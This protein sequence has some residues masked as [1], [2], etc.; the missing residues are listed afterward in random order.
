MSGGSVPVRYARAL[1][2]LAEEKQNLPTLQR[3]W[4]DLAETFRES[5]TLGPTLANPHL[6]L[7]QRERALSDLLDRL[8]A[9]PATRGAVRLLLQKGR[10]L[11]L[12]DVA[13]AFERM[14][15]ERTG[16]ARATV[17][18]A[19]PLPDDFHRS[20]QERLEKAS[21]RKLSVERNVDAEILGG[22]VARVGDVLYDGSLRAALAR[23]RERLLEGNEA[24]QV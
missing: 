6:P 24:P 14:I 21:G 22:V 17:T 3:E 18:T 12:T 19:V 10:I 13:R 1:F 11:L 4:K 7:A 23:L 15:E 5:P 9:S 16:R 20:L 2:A 8:P